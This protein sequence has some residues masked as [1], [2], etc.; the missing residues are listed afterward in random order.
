MDVYM[1]NSKRNDPCP[2]GSGKKYKKCC[3]ISNVIEISPQLYNDELGELHDELLAYALGNYEELF[4]EQ[5]RNYFQPFLN[6]DTIATEDYL[7]GLSLW[8]ILNVPL[9]ENNQT[10]F[11]AFYNQQKN[12]IKRTRT[13][14]TFLEWANTVPS[15]YEILEANNED[16]HM[17]TIIETSTNKKFQVL[18]IDEY[19]YLEG[20][21]IIGSLVPFVGFHHFFFDVIELIEDDKKRILSLIKDYPSDD[22]QFSEMFPDFLAEALLLDMDEVLDQPLNDEVANLFREHMTNKA[23]DS[24][25]INLGIDIWQTYLLIKAPNFRNPATYAAALEYLIQIIILENDAI[26]QKE[27]AQEYGTTAGTLSINYRKI[28]DFLDESIE[29]DVSQPIGYE[30]VNME[31][32]MREIQK[33]MSE[34]EFDTIED[35]ND[36][37]QQMLNSE[38]GIESTSMSPRDEAQ[39]LLYDAQ[40]AHGIN[41][42]KMIEEALK[43]YPN[44]PD[45]YLLLAE[46]TNSDLEFGE[47]LRKAVQ[48]GEKDLGKAFFLENKGHFWMMIETR[49]YM[50]AKAMYADFLYETGAEEEAFNQYEEMLRLNPNDSQGIRYILLTLYIESAQFKKAQELINEFSDEG[51]ASF[52]FNKVLVDYLTNG[53]TSQTKTY[54]KEANKQN[55]FVKRYLLGKKKIPLEDLDHMGFG[56][57]TEA[58]V[59]AQENIH[60]WDEPEL[61]KEL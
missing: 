47:Y 30:S 61:L 11:D 48:V 37:L 59:Y 1:S 17:A 15:V 60:L 55:P 13:K 22:D 31:R 42:R 52:L 2:C 36:F 39:D 16:T 3:G 54:I 6:E 43:I 41:R 23:F 26:T 24:K 28:M 51:T 5:T 45:A 50:R 33:I 29:N 9:L 27:I 12:K 25:V 44:S 8:T 35:A 19:E 53:M 58:I 34:K 10:I 7:T 21:F 38:N 56:D 4:M 46:G 18:L 40:E 14:N 20:T 32:E 49:P 57:E